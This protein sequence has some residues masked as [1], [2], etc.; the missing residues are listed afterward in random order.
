M[1]DPAHKPVAIERVPQTSLDRMHPVVRAMIDKSPDP[2][3]L[4]KLLAVQE[5]YEAG[6]ARK[7]YAAAMVALKA[8]L[9][10]IIGRDKTVAFGTTRYAHTSMAAAKEAITP[11][12]TRYGF[13]T[14]VHPATLGDQVVVTC[15][16]THAAG[17]HEEATLSAPV[18]KSGSKS[19]VQGVASTITL[20]SRYLE[21]SLLGVATR[22]M[23]DPT[24]AAA[25][26]AVDSARNLKAVSALK[27]YGKTREQAETFLGHPVAEWTTN[28]LDKLRAWLGAANKGG[29]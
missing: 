7:A 1:S 24:P 12:L 21:L 26:D 6:E 16:I 5:K 25:P 29:K 8:D 2:A 4:E 23:V 9:P 28:D 22:D 17:H 10:A 15:R 13:S 14:S 19:P 20:L 18:D 27:K 11:H 3:T